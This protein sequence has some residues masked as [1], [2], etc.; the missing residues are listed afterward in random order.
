MTFYPTIFVPDEGPLDAKILLVG[1]APGE[2]E[3]TYQRPFIGPSGDKLIEVLNR[4]GVSR[5]EVRLANLFHYRPHGNKLAGVLSTPE[6]LKGLKDLY[7]YIAS[8]KPNVIGALGAYPL[9]FL[10]G[11]YNIVNW[12][13][14]ILP[15]IHDETIKVIPTRHPSAVLRDRKLYPTFA[16]DIKR[17]IEDSTH[18]DFNYPDREFIIDPRGMDLELA[19][20]RFCAAPYLACDIETVKNSTH[21]LCVGFALNSKTAICISTRDEEGKRAIQRILDSDADKI[22]QF[23]T[24]DVRQLR[25]NKYSINPG[26][27]CKERYP[28]RL[29]FWDTML[30]QHVMAP[31]LPR[32]LEFLTSIHTRQPYYKTEGR[33]NKSKGDEEKKGSIPSDVKSWNENVDK[34]S[35][36]VYNC[37]DDVCTFEIFEKQVEES[38]YFPNFSHTFD[39]E[40]DMLEVVDHMGEA[41]MLIDEERRDLMERALI[42]KWETKQWALNAACRVKINVKSPLLK[43]VLYEKE[44][45]GLPTRRNRESGITTDEDAI[46]SLIAFAKGKMNEVVKDSTKLQWEIKL[47]ILK[48]IL[49]IRGIRQLLSNYI[50]TTVGKRVRRISTDGRI[51]STYKVGGTE[52]GR[53][54]GSKYC[55]GSGFNPQTPPRDPIEIS[56]EEYKRLV[57]LQKAA[58]IYTPELEKELEE[59]KDSEE[60]EDEE[61][62]A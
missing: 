41:G 61:E 50:R 32:S 7:D 56:E 8:A 33:G 39:F 52:T 25:I 43:K 36:F 55:D 51:H 5:E 21:I 17:I 47:E 40:M 2:E 28:D 30:A 13:G 31:E 23:G 60:E 22:F 14:S 49:E 1:E 62:A 12:R 42:A 15:Y 26:K 9:T 27:Q 10:T 54:S 29:Y 3:F 48:T 46:V 35:L 53:W 6:F 34:Q 19:V 24:F 45:L 59:E 44:Y 37:K 20:Q 16:R 57:E 4:Y 18:R 38:V 58:N 11:K